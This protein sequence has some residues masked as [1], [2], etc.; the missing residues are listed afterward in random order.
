MIF[1]DWHGL[2]TFSLL[3]LCRES[4]IYF[5]KSPKRKTCI[6]YSVS[7]SQFT[8]KPTQTLIIQRWLMFFGVLYV[9]EALCHNC[10]THVLTKNITYILHS[11]LFLYRWIISKTNC[12][13]LSLNAFIP[14]YEYKKENRDGNQFTSFPRFKSS[15]SKIFSKRIILLYFKVRSRDETYIY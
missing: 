5:A 10:F 1:G 15:I 12:F 13:C 6:I 7:L 4:T 11:I 14:L 8:K 2:I 9:A 3:N